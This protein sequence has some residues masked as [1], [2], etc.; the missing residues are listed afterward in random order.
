MNESLF[1]STIR[2]FFIGLFGMTGVTLG[3]LLGIGLI[4]LFSTVETEPETNYTTDILPNAKGVRKALTLES[5]LILRININGLIGLEGSDMHSV[6]QQLVESREGTLGDRVKALLLYIESPGGTV[7]DADGIYQAIKTYKEQYKVPVYAYVDGLC[8][9]GGMYIACAADK[10]LASEVSVIGSVG[11]LTPPFMNVSQ[12]FDKVGVSS[13]TLSAGKGKDELNPFR[14]WKPDESA[15]IQ[16]LINYYYGV[17][18]EIVTSNRPGLDRNKLV[19]DY[20]AK[21][22]PA[23]MAQEYGYIDQS[24]VSYRDALA[25]LVEKAGIK[26]DTY[27][28]I[29]MSKPWYSGLFKSQFSLLKGE[30][31]HRVELSPEMHPK[32]ANKFLYLYRS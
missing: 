29:Q 4:S 21:V 31:T 6:R 13:L 23:K 1:K 14:P 3:V 8:A 12:L 16:E 32:L 9:S 11:V 26:E 17:F 5:P 18:L 27:Q 10:I 25:L 15:N 30:M 24:G 2:S 7:V 20:G 22:Y 28:V 19:E